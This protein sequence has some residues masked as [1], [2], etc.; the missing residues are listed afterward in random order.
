MSGSLVQKTGRKNM[1]RKWRPV[2]GLLLC[3]VCGCDTFKNY[4]ENHFMVGPEY[5]RPAAAVEQNWIDANDEHLRPDQ[6][7]RDIWWTTFNDPVLNSLISSAYG[8]NLTLREAGFRVMQSR[9]ARGIAIG[10]FFP[11]SQE[12]TGGYTRKG[13]SFEVANRSA[14]PTRFFDNFDYGFG[15][16]WELDFWGRFRRAIEAADADLCASVFNYDAVLVTLLADVATEYV[17]IRTLQSRIALAEKNL[18]LQKESLS[19]AQA[20]LK[21]GQSSELDVDQAETLV[22]Q[23]EGPIEGY[24]IQLRQASNQL[25][26]LLGIPPEDLSARLGEGPIPT[27]GPE[28]G[29]GMPVDLLRQRPDVRRAERLAAAQC[30]RIGVAVSEFYPHISLVGDFG[31]A[32]QWVPEL[33]DSTAFFGQVGPSVQWNILNYG[34]IQNN[35]LKQDAEFQRLVTS[36]RNTVLNANAE[37]ENAIVLYLRSHK[38]AII[39]EQGSAAAQRSVNAVLA[40]YKDGISDFNR[41][42][43]VEQTLVQQQDLMAVTQGNIALGLIDIYRSLGG[44]WKIRCPGN[45]GVLEDGTL[46][47]NTDGAAVYAEGT[48]PEGSD[49]ETLVA[50]PNVEKIFIPL[51]DS[52]ELREVEST[53]AVEP[54]AGGDAVKQAVSEAAAFEA[55]DEEDDELTD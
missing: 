52:S 4:V 5:R 41:V 37:V 18:A 42:V 25:C 22:A 34:R 29:V 11:Q 14:T 46:C 7:D 38:Q 44:G 17:N 9:A 26:V 20:R 12:F 32:A 36:Y 40:Q 6:A 28:V 16:Q 30:A 55:L 45:Q 35:V 50:D 10:N 43:V 31:Y 51:I 24:R 39:Y 2:L 33:F 27:A 47:I 13:V 48:A 49:G 3:S 8:Q 15:L 23:T 21:S 19:L 1:L 53:P 54:T